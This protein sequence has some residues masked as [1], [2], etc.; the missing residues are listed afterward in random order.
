MNIFISKLLAWY[1]E[2]NRDL[3]WRHTKN[4]YNIWLSEVILQ[5]TRVA[6]GL[7]YYESFLAA[8]PTVTD[9]ANASE[10]QVLKLWQGLGYYSRAQNLHKAAKIIAYQYQGVF[11]NSYKELIALPGIGSY[12][13]SAI[14]SICFNEP[15]AVVDGNVYRVLARYFDV[16]FP[17]NKPV[18]I[19]YFQELAQSL[20]D[21][22]DPGI[23]NQAIMEFGAM[24]CKPRQPICTT[25]P[26]AES[27][28]SLANNIIS[29]RPQKIKAKAVKNRFF[30]YLVPLDNNQNTL[31]IKRKE[32]DIWQ[33][34]YE[35]PLLEGDETLSEEALKS[36]PKVPSWAEKAQWIKFDDK[37]IIHKLSH[38]TLKAHF[39]ILECAEEEFP[40]SWNNVHTYGVPRLIERFLHKFSR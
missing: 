34:L 25:C 29:L 35:F 11:P 9:L 27:C 38:Q 12:T 18:G 7:P 33:G 10:D 22:K 26:L 36:H 1:N 15:K 30:H 24:Q 40:I 3:P 8:F 23:Y 20:I 28:R 4:P 21:T 31:L 19:R 5:Q 16:E 14:A 2:N 13:A 17:I 39:W 6:Q 32:K 37:E